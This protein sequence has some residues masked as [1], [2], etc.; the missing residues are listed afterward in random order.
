MFGRVRGV[1]VD[2]C[3]VVA[4]AVAAVTAVGLV[5]SANASGGA[6]VSSSFVPIV[7]CRLV[8]TRAGSLQGTRGTPLGFAET[9]TFAVWGTNGSCTIPNTATGIASNVTAVGASAATFLTVFPADASQPTT[10]NLNPVPGQPP[11]PNQVTVGLSAAGAVKVFNNAGTLDLIVDIVGYYEPSTAGPQGPQ[12]PQ[13][14]QGLTGGQGLTGL[15]GVQGATG[16]S[17]LTGVQGA[18]G[19]SGPT[20]GRQITAL[21]TLDSTGDVGHFTSITIGAD[22]YPVIS[23]YDVTNGDL[24]VAKCLNPACTG[25]PTTTTLDSIGNVGDFTSITIGAD[26]NPVI[27]Y[28]DV[29]NADL[30]VAKCLNPACTGTPTT[31]TLDSIGDVGYYTSITIGADANPVISYYDATNGDLKVAKLSRTSW[32]PNVWGR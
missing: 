2:V 5:Q 14:V 1:G 13:G 30:K 32:A 29:T 21:A 20:F 15:T 3:V 25:T 28:Y 7:P 18:T 19:V 11:T 12:G 16:V 24:K 9:V 10:S 23:Y 8:D 26:A 22:G 4:L 17:G 31:T 27:S 6:T